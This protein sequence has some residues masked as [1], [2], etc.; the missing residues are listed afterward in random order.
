[1]HHD[2]PIH[3]MSS[4]YK[5]ILFFLNEFRK[6][7]LQFVGQY[8]GYHFV[9][10]IVEVDWLEFFYISSY[11]YLCDEDKECSIPTP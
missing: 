11:M 7:I 8:F 3:Y 6:E 4:L 5:V 9:Q 2:D 1:M 10:S